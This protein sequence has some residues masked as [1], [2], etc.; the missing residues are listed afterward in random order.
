MLKPT[1]VIVFLILAALSLFIINQDEPHQSPMLADPPIDST[2]PIA[3]P[4]ASDSAAASMAM[5]SHQAS[6]LKT[7]T[8]TQDFPDWLT[9]LAIPQELD[10]S[11]QFIQSTLSDV[12]AIQPIIALLVDKEILRKLARAVY[13]S[14][15]G[16]IVS[17]YRPLRSPN[18]RFIVQAYAPEEQDKYIVNSKN[19]TRYQQYV[20]ALTQ[21]EPKVAA[22]LYYRFSPLLE[23]AYAEL[24]LT[25]SS[26][27]DALIKTTGLIINAEFISSDAIL[28]RKTLKYPL[29]QSALESLNDIEK[30]MFRMGKDNQQQ[31]QTWVLELKKHLSPI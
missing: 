16:N 29:E 28:Y 4:V 18:G 9:D 11:D 21:L 3:R 8:A 22:Q 31:L 26:F 14:A 24:G 17:Q 2:T 10:L 19:Y 27:H 13:Q 25:E 23:Q 15:N 7:Q 5:P 20:S 6:P 30:L 1:V 12:D